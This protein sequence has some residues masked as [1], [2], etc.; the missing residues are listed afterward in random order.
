MV[1]YQILRC[2]SDQQR[3]AY[4]GADVSAYIGRQGKPP[5]E[6]AGGRVAELDRRSR[7]VHALA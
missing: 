4:E 6:V 5:V 1:L 7:E 2:V 3:H